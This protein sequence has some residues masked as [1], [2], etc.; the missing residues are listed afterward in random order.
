MQR[1]KTKKEDVNTKRRAAFNHARKKKEHR[2]ILSI[3]WHFPEK[4]TTWR[5]NDSSLKP[6]GKRKLLDLN[7]RFFSRIRDKESTA[8]H[9]VGV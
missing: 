6:K 3:W 8:H 9:M 5:G 4:D 1:K 2:D 7:K